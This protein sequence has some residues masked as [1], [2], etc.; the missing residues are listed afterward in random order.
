MDVWEFVHAPSGVRE[1][2]RW[3]NK[4]KADNVIRESSGFA[5]FVN[6]LADARDHGFD[7]AVSTFQVVKE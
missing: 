1:A 3:R 2:W 4:D 6:C 5:L 7:F